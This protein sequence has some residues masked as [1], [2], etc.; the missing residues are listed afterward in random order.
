MQSAK[1]LPLMTRMSARTK[2]PKTAIMMS[3]AA[4]TIFAPCPKP[5]TVASAGGAPWAY[6]SRIRDRHLAAAPRPMTVRKGMLTTDSAITTV[7]PAKT[8]VPLAVPVASPA[9]SFGSVPSR[10]W[11]WWRE[12]MK[13]AGGG[14]ARFPQRSRSFGGPAARVRPCRSVAC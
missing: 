10:T 1:P 5:L 6:S 2:E 7:A 12:T 14:N 9:D 13:R 11:V 8:T 3:A 4:V